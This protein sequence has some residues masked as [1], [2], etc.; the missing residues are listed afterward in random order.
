M[1]YWHTRTHRIFCKLLVTCTIPVTST[2]WLQ[3]FKES[4]WKSS[5]CL[6]QLHLFKEYERENTL[7]TIEAV[8]FAHQNNI[9]QIQSLNES[10]PH[11]YHLQDSP[12][13]SV[14]PYRRRGGTPTLTT[15][16]VLIV[17]FLAK[18]RGHVSTVVALVRKVLVEGQ[19]GPQLSN[20]GPP[21]RHVIFTGIWYLPVGR[22]IGLWVT[23]TACGK[24]QK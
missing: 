12:A 7:P 1:Y 20:R 17:H 4:R 22:P 10:D 19:G 16:F 5:F 3:Y 13:R 24:R 2:L 6:H 15:S 11:T 21:H 14:S 23:A 9:F 18:R 8:P